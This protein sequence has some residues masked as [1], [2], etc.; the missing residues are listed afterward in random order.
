MR[1][2]IAISVAAC[3]IFCMFVYAHW[4][5]GC[6]LQWREENAEL[7]TISMLGI[8]LAHFFR[9]YWYSVVPLLV[10]IPLG[11]AMVLARMETARL[12]ELSKEDEPMLFPR[13]TQERRPHIQGEYRRRRGNVSQ[14]ANNGSVSREQI[15][16]ERPSLR[17]KR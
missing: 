5:I 4:M 3:L 1:Y 17:R 6:E 10:I 2:V 12:E 14:V 13:E 8:H 16:V 7:S 15:A 11:V 9:M